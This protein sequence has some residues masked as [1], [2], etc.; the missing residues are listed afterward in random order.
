MQLALT[1][2]EVSGQISVFSPILSLGKSRQRVMLILN[3]VQLHEFAKPDMQTVFS[4]AEQS[5][6]L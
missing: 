4:P 6:M 2:H 5:P 3:L 1:M